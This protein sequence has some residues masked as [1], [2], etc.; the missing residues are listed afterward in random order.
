MPKRFLKK[1]ITTFQKKVYEVVRKIPKGKVLSYKEV[2][3][4][5]GKPKAYRLVGSILNKNRNSKIPCYRV[6]KSNR[7]IGGY[8][9]GTERKAT[10]LKKEGVVIKNWRVV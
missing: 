6:I 4:L 7:E 9:Y 3:K 2:A 8:R 10:L 1:P 5:A